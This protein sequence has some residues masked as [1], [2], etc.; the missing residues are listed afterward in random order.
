[1]SKKFELSADDVREL[2]EAFNLFDKDKNGMIDCEELREVMQSLGQMPTQEQLEDMIHE[3]DTDNDGVVDFD[4]FLQMMTKHRLEERSN[5]L[6]DL[7]DAFDVFD[8]NKDGVISHA[9]LKT[10]MHNLGELLTDR[11]I[12]AMINEV[13]TDGDGNVNFDEFVTLLK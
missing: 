1:M 5:Y 7:S 4:E 8:T 2:K 11:E 9:E 13:D 12:A 10:M 6:Q 3:I